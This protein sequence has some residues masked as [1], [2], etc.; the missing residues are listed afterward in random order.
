[1]REERRGPDET[2]Q[3][4]TDVAH[5]AHVSPSQME[6]SRAWAERELAKIDLPPLTAEQ[7][8]LVDEWA[9]SM[10]RRRRGG[11]SADQSEPQ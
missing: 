8:R 3:P 4:T 5:V 1:L 10:R 9:R 2:S 6:E 11:P 7:E